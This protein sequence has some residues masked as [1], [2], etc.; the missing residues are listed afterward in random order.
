[1]GLVVSTENQLREMKRQIEKLSAGIAVMSGEKTAPTLAEFA[2]P[3]LEA[4]LARPTRESTKKCKEY[5]VRRYLVP[6]LGNIPLDK[7]GNA[8]WNALV[9]MTREDP[10]TWNITRYFNPRKVLCMIMNAAKKRG[11]IEQKPEFDNPD[12]RKN[13]GRVLTDQ[14]KWWILRHTTYKLFRLFFYT[15]FKT[16]C[17]PREILRWRR[18]MLRVE[19]NGRLWVDIPAEIV[20][21]G[22]A[23]QMP[24]DQKVAKHIIRHLKE[25]PNAKFVF[26][27]RIHPGKP[28]LS[29]HGA[30]RTACDKVKRKH[31][32]FKHAVLYD[33]RRTKI[34]NALLKGEN[35]V[36]IGQL[37]D[38]SAMQ[39]NN[40]YAKRDA[41]KLEELAGI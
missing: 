39:I 18:D 34:T 6:I 8:D 5:Q 33:A 13:V 38:T 36:F 24:V 23:R 40:T 15:A 16:G 41:K 1:M 17:R 14:E 4:E 29:Y 19:E 21:T 20:K 11:L 26:E 35:P 2:K 30:W 22:R 12:E 3:W 28:Q 9:K 37:L 27:N 7:L 31:P 25:N 32:E 10:K